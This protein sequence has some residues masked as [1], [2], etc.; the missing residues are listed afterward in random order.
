[1]SRLDVYLHDIPVGGLERTDQGRLRFWYAPEAR[2]D[3]LPPL[4]LSLPI[5]A[6][7]FTDDECRGYFSGLLPEGGFLR[8]VARAFGV[9]ASNAFSV[10]E[11]IGGE[12]AGA[13]SLSPPGAGRPAPGGPRWLDARE[14]HALLAE[15][16]ERILAA[17]FDGEGLRLSLAGVQEKLPVIF[18]GGKVGITGGEPPSTDI[19]KLPITGFTDTVPNES[20]CLALATASGLSAVAAGTRVAS[21]RAFIGEP[22][23]DS[24]PFLQVTRYDRTKEAPVTRIHQEDFC[25]ALGRPP[26]VKY[27]TDGGPGVADCVELIGRHSAVP[28]KDRLAF[29]EALLFNLV[30]GNLDAHS[31][32]YSLI[33][34]GEDAPRLAPLYDL[35]STSIYPGL[36]RKLAM[37][38]GGENRP[39]YIRP[40]HLER[41]A[42]DLGMRPASLRRRAGDLC[43]RI[44]SA[45]PVADE[46]VADDFRDP[47]THEKLKKRVAEGIELLRGATISVG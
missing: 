21:P 11:A 40:R 36:T 46:Q 43:E 14:L 38:I 4:S 31:K 47:E 8:A 44:E 32:N 17:G 18:A 22:P 20:Y 6:E 7:P 35:L 2:P 15:S 25:Q 26:E 19:I 23:S 45:L 5:R 27:E 10:L 30:I 33:L 24:I 3:P 13:V 12:C 1:M 29:A 9:S 41:L 28:A 16:P 42:A 34:E 37:K 39:E